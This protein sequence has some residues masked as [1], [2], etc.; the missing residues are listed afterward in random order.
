M[1]LRKA[2]FIFRMKYSTAAPGER[3]TMFLSP[4]SECRTT[5]HRIEVVR[6]FPATL[7]ACWFS[8]CFSKVHFPPGAFVR[9]CAVGC[10]PLFD[11]KIHNIFIGFVHCGVLL[12][13]ATCSL[14]GPVTTMLAFQKLAPC[15]DLNCSSRE[16][17]NTHNSRCFIKMINRESREEVDFIKSYNSFNREWQNNIINFRCQ[18]S[19]VAARKQST[20][21]DNLRSF[22][23]GR[24]GICLSHPVGF[25]FPIHRV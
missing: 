5:K 7:S 23:P 21:S 14:K 1:L 25:R 11:H 6:S 19:A 24:L 2:F 15:F 18:T 16:Q 4:Q 8:I 20:P 10:V 3:L 17:R 12:R 13:A 9:E 22:S